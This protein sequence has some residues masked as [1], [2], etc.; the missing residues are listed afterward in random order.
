MFIGTAAADTAMGSALADTLTGEGDDDTL[1]GWDGDDT[2]AGGA[3]N[4]YLDG[5]AG[6]DLI[7]GNAGD[8]TI[9][10]GSG[11]DTVLGGD[12]ADTIDGGDGDDVITGHQGRDI[13][14]G[15]AGN[16]IFRATS[17]DGD[18]VVDGGAG[19]D[20]A[21]YS[22]LNTSVTVFLSETGVGTAVSSDGGSDT[23]R[24]IE[25]V[26]GG[27]GDDV[28]VA[29]TAANV[30]EGGIGNDIFVFNSAAHANGDTIA[31][32]HEGDLIDLQPLFASLS[33]GT[34]AESHF[35]AATTF[36]VAGEF[37]LRTDGLDT[38][39]EGTT[40]ADG[41]IDFSIRILNRTDLDVTSDFT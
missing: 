23:L 28:I 14:N 11:N 3:G 2:I 33:L 27:A 10:A 7:L 36:N 31:D 40:D 13:M 32:F 12:G 30:M 29:S 35:N 37:R 25:N 26:V 1:F 19:I 18:D 24:G 17:G 16:D 15:G 20:T 21:D 22:A 8:D 38:V 34:D 41:D 5:G 4:D 6:D 9:N 39:I